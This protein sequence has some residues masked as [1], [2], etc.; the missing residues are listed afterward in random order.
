M[1][2]QLKVFNIIF[3]LTNRLY[4]TKLYI[5]FK[6]FLYFIRPPF[7]I[8]A[9]HLDMAGEELCNMDMETF[10]R[11]QA[12]WRQEVYASMERLYAKYVHHVIVFIFCI[13]GNENIYS[14][15]KVFTHLMNEKKNIKKNETW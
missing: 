3:G 4:L 12:L 1:I 15:I 6:F 2:F 9:A 10:N 14:P 13:K 8:I 11:S 5:G 7:K